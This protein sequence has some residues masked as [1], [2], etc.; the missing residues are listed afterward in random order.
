MIT[1]RRSLAPLAASA[2]AVTV[3][4]TGL[5]A[6]AA[7][8]PPEVTDKMTAW[9]ILVPGQSG[10]GFSSEASDQVQTYASFVDTDN[11]AEEELGN[12]FHSLQF[13]VENVTDEYNPPGRT[14]VTIYRDELGVPAVY[15]DTDEALAYGIGYAMA[16]DRM[17]Q[18]DLL[19]H[20]SRGR[21][22]EMLA[23]DEDSAALYG[24]VDKVTRRD[25]Y[26]TAEM[27]KMFDQLDDR[28]GEV[29]S[30]G[31]AMLQA[32]ADGVNAFVEEANSTFSL[33][34]EYYA[35]GNELEPWS[36]VDTV[37]IAVY[38]G[39][40]LGAD[41][42]DEVARAGLLKRLRSRL[43]NETGTAVF[44]DLMYLNDP[45]AY[46]SIQ[47]EDGEFPSPTFTD[48][49]NSKAIAV[50]DNVR[51]LAATARRED[52]A[53]EKLNRELGIMKL[54]SNGI[55]VAG[56]ASTSGDP[57]QFGAPQLGYNAPASLWEVEAHSPNFDYAGVAI[58]GSPGIGLGRTDQHAWMIPVG[59]GDMMDERAELLCNPKGGK[60]R[61]NSKYYVFKGKCRRMSLRTETVTFNDEDL[62]P[63]RFKVARTVHGPVVARATVKGKPVA[64]SQQRS[65]WKKE[66]DVIAALL[67]WSMNT[68]N[69]V[70]DFA[71]GV[72]HYFP[73][74]F[75]VLYANQDVAAY[76]YSGRH[77]MRADGV[78][79]RLPSW[80][81]G[82]WE[83]KG[84]ISEEQ[85]PHVVDPAQ[86][87]LVNWNSKPSAGWNGSAN[88]NWGPVQRVT[89]LRDGMEAHEGTF[90]LTDIVNVER[91]AATQDA[92]A[93]ELWQHI[94]DDVIADD[95]TEQQVF[96]A[97][98][99]W[100]AAGAHRM[101][102]DRDMNQDNATAVAAWDEML[103]RLLQ[104][105]FTD[106][107][108]DLT[109]TGIPLTD[110]AR[111]N[112]GSSY[113]YGMT[114]YLWNLVAGHAD[115]YSRNYCDNID[116][117]ATEDCAEAIRGAFE[118]AVADLTT[119]LGADPAA[120]EYPAEYLRFSSLGS[121]TIPAPGIPWQ[122]RGTWNHAV[123]IQ[124]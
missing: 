105:V 90:S 112:N 26:T 47:T 27:Q 50:P 85:R 95:A 122:N 116:S 17:W 78:D 96:T 73:F 100:V 77:V 68:T 63:L 54:A 5:G 51:A 55:V 45:D 32:Y 9:G 29:G 42:G 52:R 120:W 6:P 72:E 46:P 111:R 91:E 11:I 49:Y 64:I 99:E 103:E 121:V 106:E 113:F 76:W 10:V 101:D 40:S 98:D 118:G 44:Q 12:Y 102:R 88:G 38:Q 117:A 36:V 70:E 53:R 75:N 39:R 71:Y 33:P 93:T 16:E 3:L 56:S 8:A 31:Q 119:E 109:S 28:F 22:A 21:V 82:K 34:A 69:S 92:N 65:T 84:L 14:D 48:T 104:D 7:A 110:D 59:V 86:G 18:I 15:G 1:K 35:T 74:S 107:I 67:Y 61:K 115:K 124:D 83:W 123:Q 94:K 24:G 114:N 2:M 58:P 60:V 23:D 66:P 43:G 20:L 4:I 62:K 97:I 87:W 37:A 13:G 30:I 79:P 89:L 81:T 25:G 108:G 19:R 57:M 80:G 41:G